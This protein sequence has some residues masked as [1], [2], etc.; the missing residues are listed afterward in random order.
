MIPLMSESSCFFLIGYGGY[1][2]TTHTALLL[3]ERR[4]QS[5]Y[6]QSS[7]LWGLRALSEV[8]RGKLWDG[9][10]GMLGG[11]NCEWTH[12]RSLVAQN[13]SI[14]KSTVGRPSWFAINPSEVASLP[15]IH[16]LAA[17]ENEGADIDG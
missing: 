7:F 11:G 14:R 2:N 13:R 6:C 3:L 17:M 15:I 1:C 12:P 5:S 4:R 8:R 9:M 10:G 16:Q